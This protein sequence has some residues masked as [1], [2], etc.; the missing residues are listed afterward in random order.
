M[1]D[2]F[3]LSEKLV[4]LKERKDVLKRDT[5]KNNEQIKDTEARMVELMLNEEV[6]NFRKNDRTFYIKTKLFA[7]IP[8]EFKDVIIRWFKE[9][10][11]Y[12][13]MVKEQINAKSLSSWVKERQ[14]EEDMPEEV[15]ARLKIYEETSI[16]IRSK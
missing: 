7:S 6:Q 10:E 4:G 9:H 1:E 8:D 5:E 3:K 14:E 12:S 11:E 15:E 16:G 13:G 2:L